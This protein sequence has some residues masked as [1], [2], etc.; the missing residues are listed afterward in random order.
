M[1]DREKFGSFIFGKPKKKSGSRK[2]R[3]G[4]DADSDSDDSSSTSTSSSGSS[5]SPI[6]DGQRYAEHRGDRFARHS[7]AKLEKNKETKASKTKKKRQ[8]R[9]TL[10]SS[11]STDSSSL[12]IYDSEIEAI[13]EFEKSKPTSTALKKLWKN[14]KHL[15]AKVRRLENAASDTDSEN[16]AI[17]SKK[18]NKKSQQSKVKSDE[19]DGVEEAK[20][21]EGTSTTLAE[22]KRSNPVSGKSDVDKET[23]TE[24]KEEGGIN[25]EHTTNKDDNDDVKEPLASDEKEKAGTED[26]EKASD[27]D[28][29]DSSDEGELEGDE[30]DST[31]TEFELK[32]QF[33]YR[34]DQKELNNFYDDRISPFIRVRWDDINHN[35][36]PE[37]V[38]ADDQKGK[39]VAGEIDII[40]ISLE[41]PVFK[42]FLAKI[43]SPPGPPPPPQRPGMM[44]RRVKVGKLPAPENLRQDES[45]SF[46]KPFR[47]LIQNRA[48]LEHKA[49]ELEADMVKS[50]ESSEL[51]QKID[52]T[53]EDS[54]HDTEVEDSKNDLG[55]QIRLL[56]DFMNEYL[57]EP[58]KKY[59]DARSG[60]LKTIRFEDLWM[61]YTPGDIIYT[62]LRYALPTSNPPAPASVPKSHPGVPN[63]PS[64]VT[65]RQGF[66]RETPQAYKIISVAGGRR[67]A[68]P[69]PP[70]RMSNTHAPLKLVC[71]FLD[72]GGYRFDVVTDTFTFRPFDTEMVI[73]DL[74]AY[75]LAY[76]SFGETSGEAEMRKFLADRGKSFI[77]VSEASH[78]L[79][80]GPAW[81]DSQNNKEEIDT[82][83]I[84]DF[85]LAYQNTPSWRPPFCVPYVDF[86]NTGVR[87]TRAEMLEITVYSRA[88]R[89]LDWFWSHQNVLIS[90]A[91]IAVSERVQGYPVVG[92]VTS[93]P[94][95]PQVIA[96]M[97]ANEDILLLP[98]MVYA[99]ALR[100]RRWVALDLM[101][102]QDTQYE[103]GWKDLILP[104]GHKEM[105][106][107]VVENHAA[108]SRATGGMK[109]GSAEVDIVRGKGKGCI[110]LLHG[111]PGV[112]KTSTA[113]CVAAFTKRPLFP[114]TCGDIGYEPDE[115]ERN[116]QKH[117]T[118]AHKWGCVMLLDEAD[119]FLAKRSRDDI[120]RNGLV[121][122]FL[123]ILE[124]YAGILFLTTN[125]VGSF[126]DA[127]RSRLHLTLYYP[128]LDKKQT[129]QIFEMNIRRV[130]ELNSKREQA[131]QRS[132]EIQDDK[133]LRFARKHCETLSWNGRQI[134][135]AF[136]TAIALAEFDVRDDGDNEPQAVMGKK[137]FK[138][139]AKA[140]IEFDN[141]LFHT[142]GGADQ[143]AKARREQV[144]WDY[145]VEGRP[146]R[147]PEL[148]DSSSSASSESSSSSS[149]SDSSSE[150]SD[151]SADKA[152][153]SD[154]D[155]GKR[156]KKKKK[157]KGKGKEKKSKK[158]D[159]KSKK[160]KS[161]KDKYA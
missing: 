141:Y 128:K 33:F 79:Y 39:V 68:E 22:E 99:F 125:R 43:T 28:D 101:L 45:V 148:I 129:L 40:E 10:S 44:G 117:F 113:E 34:K 116:L 96:A 142:H 65:Y 73:T 114:I 126:D 153:S 81:T 61:L 41:S 76:A 4:D 146:A 145:E 110:I 51:L 53:Q 85:A 94:A 115:V 52:E 47:W 11:S 112:G 158:S 149:S 91:R 82:P 106:R 58:L 88:N 30:E 108:G 133:I 92:S 104:P 87:S 15:K 138:T 59:E 5:V 13:V 122:V 3:T 19:D 46:F 42:A 69:G 75:P 17:L 9:H 120:K 121:S 23:P 8:K 136:Q 35:A 90:R 160:S 31:A 50:A 77:E 20:T 103:D 152:D 62:P 157:K 131:G 74:D 159:S 14:V 70:G 60:N 134:R 2:K 161:K 150:D 109:K 49:A 97:E 95:I 102:L 37:N 84:V 135:N 93:D 54:A 24:G 124:Y 67:F 25:L 139:I 48:F 147:K 7:A 83:V 155:D 38:K 107:A 57:A 12:S 144:R 105:V 151:S 6:L 127:F 56:I 71:Y 26:D 66:G 123:R 137:Q 86:Y 21:E 27:G 89:R 80:A 154:S 63:P 36:S 143:A 16:S 55:A 72:L 29:E 1:A 130:R 98:G 18:G 32:Y 118:L 78:K 132:V 64:P 156:R 119:V 100:D 140:S 111:E